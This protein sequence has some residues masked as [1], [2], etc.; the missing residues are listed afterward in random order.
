MGKDPPILNSC[1]FL[2]NLSLNIFVYL[3]QSRLPVAD[4]PEAIDREWV[5]LVA[6]ECG[7]ADAH[8]LQRLNASGS[9]VSFLE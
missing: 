8:A 3:V 5:Y 2:E 9:V 6:K 1:F 7:I 4:P